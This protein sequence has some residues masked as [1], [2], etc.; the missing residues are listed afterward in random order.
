L[1]SSR[2]TLGQAIKASGRGIPPTADSAATLDADEFFC[3]MHMLCILCKLVIYGYNVLE[4]RDDIGSPSKDVETLG[5]LVASLPIGTKSDLANSFLL[6][7]EHSMVIWRCRFASI[8]FKLNMGGPQRSPVDALQAARSTYLMQQR[9]CFPA[10]KVLTVICAGLP[11]AASVNDVLE[12]IFGV[13]DL[14][15]S[16]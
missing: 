13:K 16:C 14:L 6:G 12:R 15:Q 10:V 3:V 9:L 2:W 1:A 4:K 11:I 5:S 7:L 8:G